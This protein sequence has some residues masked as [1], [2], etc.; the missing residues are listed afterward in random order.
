MPTNIWAQPIDGASPRQLTRFA[1]S[2]PIADF[3]WSA[4]GQR[5]AIVRESVTNDI[6]LFKGLRR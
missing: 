5:L 6:V 4:D 2:R 3:R 1:D